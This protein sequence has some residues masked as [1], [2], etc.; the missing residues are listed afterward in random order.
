M[1]NSTENASRNAASRQPAGPRRALP[2]RRSRAAWAGS[3]DSGS[4]FPDCDRSLRACTARSRPRPASGRRSRAALSHATATVRCVP[5]SRPA[6]APSAPDSTARTTRASAS[7][8]RR[9]HGSRRCPAPRTAAR[10][11]S[12]PR[13]RRTSCG[14]RSSRRAHRP[15]RRSRARTPL[16]PGQGRRSTQ[17]RSRARAPNGS[18]RPNRPRSIACSGTSETGAARYAD[19]FATMRTIHTTSPRIAQSAPDP[20]RCRVEPLPRRASRRARRQSRD[21]L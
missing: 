21:C 8:T 6:T 10:G 11:E 19:A 2:R 5:A 1:K 12:A 13:S 7:R 17:R 18:V 15:P 16:R 3:S 4:S 14:R 9:R 20:N